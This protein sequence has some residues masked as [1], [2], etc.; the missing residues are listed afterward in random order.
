MRPTFRVMSIYL[1]DAFP[2]CRDQSSRINELLVRL[3]RSEKEQEPEHG[4]SV[5]F[6]RFLMAAAAVVMSI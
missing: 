6:S 3:E 1:K 2:A 5:F 4:G